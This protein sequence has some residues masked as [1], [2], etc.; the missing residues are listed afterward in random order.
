[1]DVDYRA[2]F[3]LFLR[4]RKANQ[5]ATKRSV[6]G[7]TLIE[8]MVVIAIIGILAIIAIPN[9]LAYRAR[10]YNAAA[11]GDGR[12]AFTAAQA[13][14]HENPDA[15]ITSVATLAAYGFRETTDMSVLVGG[16]QDT[17]TIVTYHN[18][19]DKTFTTN[20]EGRI[21]Y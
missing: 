14:F 16:T 5:M 15:S 2:G 19:G 17:L 4:E 8:L 9:F 7:F 6:K 18:A 3:V 1:M 10:A 20:F 12:N 11:N 13:F 21:S